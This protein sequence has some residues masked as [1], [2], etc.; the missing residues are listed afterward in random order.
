M[1]N[2]FSI[3]QWCITDVI[4]LLFRKSKVTAE[5][6]K[7]IFHKNLAARIHSLL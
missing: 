4:I 3:E 2:Q 7:L 1:E 6:L 5:A